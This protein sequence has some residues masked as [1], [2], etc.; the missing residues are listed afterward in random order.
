MR[1]SVAFAEKAELWERTVPRI[2]S[3]NA[4]LTPL[5][6]TLVEWRKAETRSWAHIL[7]RVG[8]EMRRRCALL[9]YPIFDAFLAATP[10]A[11]CS[12][13]T[14]EEN[15]LAMLAQWL[16]DASLHDF[17]SRL[18]VCPLLA[19][20][21]RAADRQRPALIA[22]VESMERFYAQYAPTLERRVAAARADVEEQLKNLLKVA[23]YTDLN[24][25]SVKDSAQRVHHRLCRL[26]AAFKVVI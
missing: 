21:L 14:Y 25:W 12:E 2:Y 22:K 13:A 1:S 4:Q 17:P 6:V 10:P 8:D 24:V 19:L 7:E 20:A 26:I 15:L 5:R 3:L 9:A 18:L 11:D 23:R 16:H